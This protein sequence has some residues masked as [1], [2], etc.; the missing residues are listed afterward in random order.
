M[1]AHESSTEERFPV[2]F[3]HCRFRIL[4]MKHFF[5]FCAIHSSQHYWRVVLMLYSRY[6]ESKLSERP[7]DI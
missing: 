6:S 7:I 1:T 2:V 4:R 5:I 3:V